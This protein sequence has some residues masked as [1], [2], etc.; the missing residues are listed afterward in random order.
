MTIDEALEALRDA[1]AAA[2]VQAWEP[3]ATLTALEQLEAELAPLRLPEQVRELWTRVD[4]ATVRIFPYPHFT[5]PEAALQGWWMVRDQFTAL[6]PLA[7]LNVGYESHACMSVELEVGDIE[8]GALFEWFVSEP[9]GFDRRYNALA[10]WLSDVA[11]LIV[12]GQ[13]L[14]LGSD[15]GPRLLVPDPADTDAVRA[16]RPLPGTHPVHGEVLHIGGDLFDWPEHWQRANG[17]LPEDMRPRGATHTVAEV[18]ASPPDSEL[19]GTVTARVVDLGGLDGST[20]IRV[21]D[22]SGSLDIACSAAVTLQGPRMHDW[23]EFDIVV[24]RG[25]R[26][27]PADVDAAG[28]GIDDPVTHLSATLMARYGG[29]AGATA[30]AIRRVPAPR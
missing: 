19:R 22:G 30:V 13:Y 23:F 15:R 20:R 17:L 4:V 21:D 27:L 14:R 9:S 3:P 25:N 5:T 10:D 26:V 18:L 29:P 7:L 16:A 8:G 12:R 24:A 11:N 2:D 1:C 28:A 6:Q